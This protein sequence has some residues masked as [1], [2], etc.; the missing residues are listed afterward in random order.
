MSEEDQDVTQDTTPDEETI[1]DTEMETTDSEVDV[2][3]IKEQNRQLYE[4]TKKAEAKVKELESKPKPEPSS[5]NSSASTD[6]GDER[7][8]RLE[9]KTD[10]YKDDEIDVLMQNGGKRALDNKI[11]MAGIEAMRKEAKSLGATPSGTGKSQVYQKFTERD[12]KNMPL[13]ELEKIIP[14]D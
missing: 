14:Q 7:F 9:L 11:V 6:S 8:E 13:D 4:R 3:A 12:L 1:Q 10:G 2:E 5:T